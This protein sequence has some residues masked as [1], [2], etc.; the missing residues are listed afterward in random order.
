MEKLTAFR[1]EGSD[2]VEAW[3]PIC[4]TYVS[5]V[6]ISLDCFTHPGKKIIEFVDYIYCQEC[7]TAIARSE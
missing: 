5:D 3:C 1:F 4:K 7:N 6:G 2:K